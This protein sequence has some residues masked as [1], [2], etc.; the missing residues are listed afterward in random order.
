M[1]TKL[2]I[3]LTS[4]FFI[5]F[6]FPL[7]SQQQETASPAVDAKGMQEI[8]VKW[9]TDPEFRS[10][11]MDRF[12]K[13]YQGSVEL[14]E[15]ELA[16]A[17]LLG[18]MDKEISASESYHKF[19]AKCIATLHSK[20][21]LVGLAVVA[22]YPHLF[23]FKPIFFTLLDIFRCENYS[24]EAL[25]WLAEVAASLYIANP[26][27]GAKFLFDEMT[28]NEQFPVPKRIAKELEA[29]RAKHKQRMAEQKGPGPF[30][31]Y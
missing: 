28:I 19:L 24:A 13:G 9:K 10:T 5:S 6:S 17:L 18:A 16:P 26:N 21:Q 11:M 4:L 14:S 12:K 7:Y 29:A 31:L 25:Y 30:G 23:D 8:L 20:Q 15:N 1:S 3:L 2:H 27:E 22:K